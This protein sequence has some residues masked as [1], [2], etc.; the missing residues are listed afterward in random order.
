MLLSKL[1]KHLLTLILKPL[2]LFAISDIHDG[3]RDVILNPTKYRRNFLHS[4]NYLYSEQLVLYKVH[5]LVILSVNLSFVKYTRTY[6]AKG[7]RCLL[8]E[9]IFRYIRKSHAL[10]KH[11]S[12]FRLNQYVWIK[13]ALKSLVCQT[14]I[15]RDCF[16]KRRGV[17]FMRL[18]DVR[19]VQNELLF[20]GKSKSST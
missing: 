7:L 12:L 16:T 18:R 13:S 11:L 8:I 4:Y 14:L 15:E 19:D 9:K 10:L 2:S 5:S 6:E 20:H 17:L 1:N 3:H